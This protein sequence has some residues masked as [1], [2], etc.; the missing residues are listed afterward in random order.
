[1]EWDGAV[2]GGIPPGPSSGL[3]LEGRRGPR[4]GQ[5]EA[6]TRGSTLGPRGRR[7]GRGVNGLPRV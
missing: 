1:M 4:R 5:H 7:G 3:G 6:A 2:V